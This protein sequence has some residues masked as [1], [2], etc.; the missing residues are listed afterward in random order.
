VEDGVPSD[1]IN[2][3]AGN[4][5]AGRNSELRLIVGQGPEI[6]AMPLAIA[7][8]TRIDPAPMPAII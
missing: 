4:S 5:P 6:R 1:V 8:R 7:A 3:L 2:V